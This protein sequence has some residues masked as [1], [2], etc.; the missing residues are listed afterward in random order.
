MTAVMAILARRTGDAGSPA[1][2]RDR[3]GRRTAAGSDAHTITCADARQGR[4]YGCARPA[5]RLREVTMHAVF[6]Q[7]DD[8]QGLKGGGS[9]IPHV[10]KPEQTSRT[11]LRQR[12]PA[13]IR[14]PEGEAMPENSSG[15]IRQSGA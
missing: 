14:E 12:Q 2:R 1:K 5:G 8:K 6:E 15:F 4:D 11:V 7:T 9:R 13:S 10:G 3:S